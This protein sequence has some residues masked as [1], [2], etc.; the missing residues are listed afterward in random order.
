MLLV[1]RRC[2]DYATLGVK[3]SGYFDI[4]PDGFNFGEAPFKAFCRLDNN[5]NLLF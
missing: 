4:D 3:R 2:K 1:P 5:G